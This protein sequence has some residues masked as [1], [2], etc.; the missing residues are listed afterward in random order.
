MTDKCNWEEERRLNYRS[1]ALLFIDRLK[2]LEQ[3]FESHEDIIAGMK[4]TLR[5]YAEW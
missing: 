5:E 3:E 4:D 1:L 2:Q